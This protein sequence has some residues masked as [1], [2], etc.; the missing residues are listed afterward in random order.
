MYKN[1]PNTH[2]VVLTDA[3]IF[4]SDFKN[5]SLPA[6]MSMTFVGIG[7]EQGGLILEGYTADGQPSYRQFEGKN[8]ISRLDKNFLE[9]LSEYFSS[10][11]FIIS[12]VSQISVIEENLLQIF[13]N[14]YKNYNFFSIFGV[15]FLLI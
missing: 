3:E 9:K 14:S 4:D 10:K 11:N 15:I 5:I 6:Y 2:I 12:D 13:S 7:T 8:V 1:R